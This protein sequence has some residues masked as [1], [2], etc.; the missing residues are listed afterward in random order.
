MIKSSQFMLTIF[1]KM[2]KMGDSYLKV[3]YFTI[4]PGPK[5]VYSPLCLSKLLTTVKETT[6]FLFIC[7]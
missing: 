5:V 2:I 4:A 3:A 1:K 6:C 7:S